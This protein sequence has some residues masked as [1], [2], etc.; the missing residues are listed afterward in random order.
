[1]FWELV[2]P[3]KRFQNIAFRQKLS[4]S[5][6]VGVD[7]C[8]WTTSIHKDGLSYVLMVARDSWKLGYSLANIAGNKSFLK[9][10]KLLR[11]FSPS[12]SHPISHIFHPSFQ[13][14]GIL[15]FP[16]HYSHFVSRAETMAMAMFNSKV[17][18]RCAR[19][20]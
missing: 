15:P 12:G 16:F 3:F 4:L 10:P 20:E 2:Y 19:S 8:F 18:L 6:C 14:F 7:V 17:Q 13:K 5:S 9:P 1:M 11:L